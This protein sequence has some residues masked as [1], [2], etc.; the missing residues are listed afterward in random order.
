MRRQY[1]GEL[2]ER[3]WHTAHGLFC[4]ALNSPIDEANPRVFPGVKR[5]R[6]TKPT[7]LSPEEEAR[8]FSFESF[9]ELWGAV[10]LNQ[11]ESGGL[12]ALHAHV[13]HSC[14]PNLQVAFPL[15]SLRPVRE[16]D[17]KG[18]N[19]PKSYTL[20]TADQLPCDLPPSQ[21]QRGTNK[22]TFLARRTIHPGEELT[23]PYVNP[24]M[25]K[26]HR[27]QILREQ[28]GF[29][30][31]C[32][33][34]QREKDDPKDSVNPFVA[35]AD[36]AKAAELV[37][38]IKAMSAKDTKTEESSEPPQQEEATVTAIEAAS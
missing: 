34:C 23:L 9:L 24:A 18:R 7:P 3:D 19:L 6:V 14:E 22:L 29:W 32:P 4:H 31:N 37:D 13:N 11:E 12:Y 30:C 16:T 15:I 26:F 5:R 2:R 35:G 21:S 36:E 20:P 25:P 33:K 1:I 38:A 27:R 17:A 8:W 28:Y 10:G